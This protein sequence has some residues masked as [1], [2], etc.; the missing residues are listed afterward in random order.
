MI[1]M[2]FLSLVLSLCMMISVSAFAQSELSLGDFN[3]SQIKISVSFDTGNPS[4]ANAIVCIYED[5]DAM[6]DGNPP[7]YM[8]LISL[9][10]GRADDV[11]ILMPN[12]FAHGSYILS[13]HYEDASS[14]L[15][16]GFIYLNDTELLELRKAQIL[17][18]AKE[19]T[20]PSDA[21]VLSSAFFDVNSDG[22]IKLPVNKD[23]VLSD[24]DMTDYDAVAAKTEVFIRMIDSGIGSLE[25]YDELIDLFESCATAQKSAENR[26]PS[27]ET[28]APDND[29]TVTGPITSTITT[30]SVNTGSSSTGGSTV[31]G[32]TTAP[33][34]SSFNDMKG[35]WAEKYAETLSQKKIINGYEDGSFKGENNT[36]R[37]ELAKVYETIHNDKGISGILTNVSAESNPLLFDINDRTYTETS[38]ENNLNNQYGILYPY[39]AVKAGA[40][41]MRVPDDAEYMD[42]PDFY[43]ICAKSDLPNGNVECYGYDVT[44]SGASFVLWVRNDG[45][46]SVTSSTTTGII[47]SVTDGVN[48]EGSKVKVIRL[49]HG[50]SWKKAYSPASYNASQS[51]IG[52]VDANNKDTRGLK[53]QIE[54]LKPGDMVRVSINS[55]NTITALQ[56]DF[57]YADRKVHESGSG[58]N[59][60]RYNRYQGG[61]VG[62]VAGYVYD[63]RDNIATILHGK[64][65]DEIESNLT[66][67]SL[68]GSIY[69]VNLG[70]GTSIFVEMKRDRDTGEVISAEVYKESNTKNIKSYYAAGR[71]A[72]YIVSRARIHAVSVNAIYVN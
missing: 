32:G 56:I 67:P 15:S 33:S 26:G 55:K 35:H 11:E 38:A 12:G 50:G 14:P 5:G 28:P 71:E 24:A 37:A 57:S 65:L 49:Y 13:V 47:E 70:S 10:G 53:Q 69:P 4:I 1:K 48:D 46:P 60:A 52:S 63:V 22:G 40:P 25:S 34:A 18:E 64:S 62:I 16:D 23:I 59:L 42:D 2:K 20:L 54:A 58:E 36:T 51:A 3:H 6:S 41:I 66:S 29:N 44:P 19:I 30:P 45:S 39:F 8:D 9:I 27:S 31:I 17:E 7:L 61:Y 21:S 72:D 43:Q 68:L